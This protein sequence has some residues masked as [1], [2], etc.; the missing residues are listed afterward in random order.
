[1]AEPVL[2]PMELRHIPPKHT[3]LQTILSTVKEKALGVR[4]V[5]KQ[6]FGLPGEAG[7]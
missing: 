6:R 7:L 5:Y 1:M 2:A 4:R 3:H